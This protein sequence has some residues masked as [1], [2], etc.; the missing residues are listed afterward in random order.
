[1]KKGQQP[2]AAWAEATARYGVQGPMPQTRPGGRN[3]RGAT[4]VQHALARGSRSG[5]SGA[6][7][8]APAASPEPEDADV[9]LDPAEL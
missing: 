4:M 7:A 8:S 5:A 3:A 6:A 9:V 2:E 1:M